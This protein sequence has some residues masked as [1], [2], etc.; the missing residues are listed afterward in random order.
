MSVTTWSQTTR[1]E[2]N[3]S[4]AIKARLVEMEEMLKKLTEEIGALRQENDALRRATKSWMA[5]ESPEVTSMLTRGATHS[6]SQQTKK[7]GKMHLELQDLGDKYA[8]IAKQMGTL[9][10]V[11]HCLL[12][13]I[14]RIA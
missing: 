9:S 11:D 8:K 12:V 14:C 1:R 7:D 10:I 2:E 6:V 4:K 3:R 5:E 13:L